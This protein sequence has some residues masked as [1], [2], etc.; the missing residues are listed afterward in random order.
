MPAEAPLASAVAT[1]L[2]QTPSAGSLPVCGG[3]MP[4]VK[5]ASTTLALAGSGF[6]TGVLSP[7]AR[8]QARPRPLATP[9]PYAASALEKCSTTFS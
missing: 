2:R 4:V 5:P 7:A 3:S 6:C 9:A 8:A 1:R